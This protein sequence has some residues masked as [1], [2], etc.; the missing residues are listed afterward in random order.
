MLI[1]LKK[2]TSLD[3]IISICVFTHREKD[4]SPV[5]PAHE[6][7][8]KTLRVQCLSLSLS[9]QTLSVSHATPSYNSVFPN[10]AWGR[11]KNRLTSMPSPFPCNPLAFCLYKSRKMEKNTRIQ[12]PPPPSVKTTQ[13]SFDILHATNVWLG[14]SFPL[15]WSLEDRPC[16][17]GAHTPFSHV[18]STRHVSNVICLIEEHSDRL[19]YIQ[20]CSFQH[21]SLILLGC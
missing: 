5:K 9:V 1:F 3:V 19:I 10:H 17:N 2:L 6:G 12:S 18:G 15:S 21:R 8:Q 20:I 7:F 14:I 11:P 16:S 4:I 13:Y